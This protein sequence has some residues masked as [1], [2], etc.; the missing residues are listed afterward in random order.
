MKRRM[1]KALEKSIKER[2]KRILLE[3]LHAPMVRAF[4]DSE[5]DESD[6]EKERGDQNVNV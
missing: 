1:R 3:L 4:K 6:D 2:Q 5:H